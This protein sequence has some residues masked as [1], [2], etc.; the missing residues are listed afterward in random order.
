MDHVVEK[1]TGFQVIGF[2]KTFTYEDA[3]REIPLF[4]G[5]FFE[6]YGHIMR[7]TAKPTTAVEAAICENAVGEYGVCVEDSAKAG[8]FRYL[9]AGRYTGGETPEGMVTFRFPD[10]LWAKFRCSGALPGALQAV[11]TAIYREW[12][13]GNVEY[14]IAMGANIE[15]YSCG[16]TAAADY[17]SA[18][19][20]PVERKE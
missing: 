2:E 19:W 20:M 1:M 11:N 14:K 3:Y 18:I 6:K 4:W 12:L 17:E 10:L 16:D 7:T 8:S 5:E 9:I 15:W 13:P